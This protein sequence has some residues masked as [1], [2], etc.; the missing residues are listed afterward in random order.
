MS[1]AKKKNVKV[2][3]EEEEVEVE[4]ELSQELIDDLSNEIEVAINKVCTAHADTDPR[5]ELLIT[6]GNL[7]TQVAFQSGF[8][9]EEF[10][11]LLGNMFDEFA[12]MENDEGIEITLDK[13]KIN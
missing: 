9:K 11:E 3:V 6:L 5:L 8:A 2:E 10:I 13:S 1:M 7:A 12:A 4:T